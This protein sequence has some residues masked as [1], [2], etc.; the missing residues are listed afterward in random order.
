MDPGGISWTFRTCIDLQ[1]VVFSKL[2]LVVKAGAKPE[3]VHPLQH[4]ML[5]GNHL[6]SCCSS[7][8][9]GI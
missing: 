5:Q 8:F 2:Q 7:A 4:H 3:Q 1:A 6:K 9:K